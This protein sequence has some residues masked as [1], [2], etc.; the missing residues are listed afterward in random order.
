MNGH[1][2]YM[3]KIIDLLTWQERNGAILKS[4][5]LNGR[6]GYG[7]YEDQAWVEMSI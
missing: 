6:D 1:L 7:Y 4:A 2:S 5:A 3:T